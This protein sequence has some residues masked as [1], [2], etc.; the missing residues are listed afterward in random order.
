MSGHAD[1][2]GMTPRELERFDALLAENQRLREALGMAQH[3]VIRYGSGS[4]CAQVAQA[5]VRLAGDTE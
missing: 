1:T 5:L 3:Y 2:E 4:E